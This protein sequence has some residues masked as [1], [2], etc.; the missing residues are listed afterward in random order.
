VN[1]RRAIKGVTVYRENGKWAYRVASEPD[2]LTGARIRPYKGGFQTEEAALRQAIEAKKILDSGRS[3][4]P[5][6]IRV[7]E[8]FQEWLKAIEPNLKETAAQSYRDIIDAYIEPILGQRWL[9]DLKVTTINSFYRYLSDGGRRKGDSNERMYQVWLQHRDERNGLGPKPSLMAAMGGTNLAGAQR[10][11]RRFRAGR[12]P[13]PYTP[14][15]SAKTV[16]NVHVVMSKAL[17]DAVTW[18]Y[19]NA[20][21]TEHAVV[22][23]LRK[24]RDSRKVWTVEELGRWLDVALEDRFAG[25]WLL[26]ATTGM[27]RSELA[28]VRRQMLDLGTGHLRVEGT[29]VVVAGRALASDGK[30]AAGRREISLD[31]F[32]CAEL[33]KLVEVLTSERRALG[34]GYPSHGLLMVNER[35]RPLHPDTITTRFNRL[36]DRAGV[37]RIRLHDVRHT[38]ATLALDEGVDPKTLSDRIGHANTSVTLQIYGHRSH[39]RDTLM[40]QALGDLI[41]SA[42]TPDGLHELPVVRKLVRNHPGDHSETAIEGE[43]TES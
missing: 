40:A 1:K 19:L 18:G 21:P 32:T 5:E 14:G 27:R 16:R 23:K 15:L 43:S 39:G 31:S 33:R 25:M 36:V 24:L 11:A 20:D 6:K 42:M 26:A 9:R 8:Y 28:G 3:P 4:H 38:Y 30:S 13:K 37:P 34:K 35:G 10:A 12:T 29:R 2:P 7:R 41:Q 22:P 17:H